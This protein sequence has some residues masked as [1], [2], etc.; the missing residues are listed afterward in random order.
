MT[1]LIWNRNRV[2]HVRDRY[3]LGP[4]LYVLYTILVATWPSFMYFQLACIQK[5]V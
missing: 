2:D 3:K 1:Q 5:L 4:N